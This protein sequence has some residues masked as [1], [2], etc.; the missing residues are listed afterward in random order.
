MKVLKV[1]Q[2]T[3]CV[4][5]AL[6]MIFSLVPVKPVKAATQITITYDAGEAAT[7]N[8]GTVYKVSA[9]AG[10]STKITTVKPIRPGCN[11]LGWTKTKGSG[12]ISFYAGMYGTF[13]KNTTFWPVWN[14]NIAYAAGDGK[15]PS[16]AVVMN[17]SVTLG[18]PVT[19]PST[20]PSR[21]GYSF[22]GW[23]T[24]KGSSNVVYKPNTTATF[25]A[26][27]TL[28]PVWKE[29]NSS[30]STTSVTIDRSGGSKTVTVNPQGRSWTISN[31][32]QD[33]KNPWVTTSRNGNNLT[34]TVSENTGTA[35]RTSKIYVVVGG[36]N[37]TKVQHII[38]VSQDPNYH[39]VTLN[40]G[41]GTISGK[42]TYS[43]KVKHNTTIK[44]AL[45]GRPN[46][47]PK[48]GRVFTY[49]TDKTSEV[50]KSE[51]SSY[52]SLLYGR[53]I[54][55]NIVL[56]ASYW[57]DLS[58][59]EKVDP[60]QRRVTPDWLQKLGI[61]VNGLFQAGSSLPGTNI[62]TVIA[63]SN[64]LNNTQVQKNNGGQYDVNHPQ[65]IEDRKEE[66]ANYKVGSNTMG[67][68][69]C[70]IAACYNARFL[71]NQRSDLVSMISR[72]DQKGYMLLGDNAAAGFLGLN[73]IHVEDVINYDG[74]NII[75]EKF[76]LS[77]SFDDA[78]ES[79][80]RAMRTNVVYII[81]YWNQDSIG[82]AHYVCFQPVY[83]DEKGFLLRAHNRGNYMFNSVLAIMNWFYS[84]VS[85]PKDYRDYKA[86]KTTRDRFI[87]G[88]RIYLPIHGSGGHF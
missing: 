6:L 79:D 35:N 86:K 27:T 51:S 33:P 74:S 24:V 32:D 9:T 26:P 21:T 31:V 60:S 7:I 46:P 56:Y 87:A 38:T 65:L 8:G 43:F 83:N 44:D 61:I 54:D 37:Q 59:Y 58:M 1:S 36:A 2:K 42:K 39:T 15:Y 30:V 73:P 55:K 40:A 34:I 19:I 11:F 57:V 18:V 67:A 49:Y 50:N 25:T 81:C 3:I 48:L 80:L 52:T 85:N 84:P 12:Q 69:G 45:K 75:V 63:T 82:S 53:K 47:V 72:V 88:Y 77:T 22:E 4:L 41:D 16:G 10:V 68:A 64:T 70:G 71:L 13:S 66:L 29:L 17:I 14:A 76:D 5:C 23:T 78:V 28:W 62:S 20:I